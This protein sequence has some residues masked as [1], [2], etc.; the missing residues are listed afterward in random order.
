[1]VA[2]HQ[3]QDLKKAL[4][5]GGQESFVKEK[6]AR[7]LKRHGIAVHTHLSWT[8]RRPPATLPKGIDLVYICT[9]MVGH[10]LAEPCVK[11]ARELGVPF[12]NGTRKWAESLERLTQAGFPLTDP[13]ESLPEI[14]EEVLATRP[15]GSKPTESDLRGI[16]IAV[17]GDVEKAQKYIEPTYNSTA[18]TVDMKVPTPINPLS[19]ILTAAL[20]EL[21][22]LPEPAP[23]AKKEPAMTVLP[24]NRLASLGLYNSKQQAYLKA[25]IQ[26]PC[27]MNKEL[28]Q[29]LQLQPLFQGCK[30]DPQR[31]ATAREQLGIKVTRGDGMRYID[32]ELEKFLETAETLKVEYTLPEAHYTQS[33][34]IPVKVLSPPAASPVA[35]TSPIDQLIDDMKVELPRRTVL[36][37][38]AELRYAMKEEN[39]TEIHVTEG[40]IEYKRVVVETG[41]LAF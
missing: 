38:L 15:P 28:W 30:L 5:V 7:S 3:S 11:Y 2:G 34:V 24:D 14:I 40:G 35:A 17:A 16:A 19:T 31:A 27:R 36:E 20:P 33:E 22:P 39:Y 8:K 21:P 37:L 41:K 23:E 4:V 29:T 10:G 1:M 26:H 6:L 12:V 18:K 32:I 13:V 25:L 9:D